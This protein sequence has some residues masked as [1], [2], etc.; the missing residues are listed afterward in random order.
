MEQD[1]DQ[2]KY[3]PF[4]YKEKGRKIN[5]HFLLE[6]DACDDNNINLDIVQ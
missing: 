6:E 4:Q 2:Q 3:S 1:V 5:L